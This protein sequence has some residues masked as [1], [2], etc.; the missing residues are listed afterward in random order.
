MNPMLNIAIRAARK[1]GN[2]IAKGYER[3]DDLQTTLKSTNDYV[4]NIDKA[5]E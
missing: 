1:A 4:T 2:V 3:R 5:S